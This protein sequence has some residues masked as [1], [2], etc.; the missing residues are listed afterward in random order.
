MKF[1]KW[2]TEYTVTLLILYAIGLVFMPMS[3]KSTVQANSITKW[4]DCYKKLTYA[5]DAILKQEQSD[6]LTS[7]KRVTTPEARENL[8]I[9]IMKPYFRL[10]DSK[11]P[12]KYKVKYMNLSLVAQK[13]IFYT[14]EYYYADNNI[15]VGIKD[16]PNNIDDDDTKFIMTFD[17]NGIMPPNTWGKDVYGIAVYREKVEPIGGNLRIEEQGMDCSPMGTG[18]SC[19]NYYLIGGGFND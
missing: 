7:F 4:K 14:E 8:F 2:R 12:R 5:Q 18:T 19:S 3:I 9:E 17:V 1:G 16:V 15:I 10:K 11:V 13:D 6:I